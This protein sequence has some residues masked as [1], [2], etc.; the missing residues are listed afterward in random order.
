MR[1][2][3]AKLSRP[4]QLA[5]AVAVLVLALG[6]TATAARLI[7]GAQIKDGSITGRDIK[8]G[9]IGATDL[10]GDA[11]NALRGR[12]G[13]RGE[14][15]A[16]G[17]KGDAGAVGPKGDTG[18]QGASGAK[19]DV[20]AP[21]ADGARGP[22]GD[23]GPA[24]PQ[25]P[26]GDAGP[27]GPKGDTGDRG[28]QGPAGADGSD[29]TRLG[30]LDANGTRLGDY[31]DT[32]STGD[33]SFLTSAGRIYQVNMGTGA[34]NIPTQQIWYETSD[35]SGPGYVW[36][37]YWSPQTPLAKSGTANAGDPIY[38]PSGPPKTITY[39]SISA[40]TC[41]SFAGNSTSI[42]GLGVARV[43]TVPA[44]EVAPLTIG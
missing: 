23:V 42:T 7:T 6:G 29:A 40:A 31:L 38:L 32:S 20:G 17:A 3:I 25:G 16:T 41:N 13:L 21:G 11:A 1:A 34:Y 14:T 5:A 4:A 22:Q 12:D 43:G 35:C 10:R 44:A 30:V 8:N 24:G 19:G 18:A 37:S 28:P 27:A 39:H 2:R 15:G 33:V 36:T 9:S 26:K